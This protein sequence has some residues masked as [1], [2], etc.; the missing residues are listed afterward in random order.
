MDARFAI[1]GN[2]VH[3]DAQGHEE[4]TAQG[5]YTLIKGGELHA[6]RCDGP[7]VC[8]NILDFVGARD[9]IFPN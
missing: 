8:I 2:W 3:I 6:D 9:I 7:E 4:L 5:S 1:Q